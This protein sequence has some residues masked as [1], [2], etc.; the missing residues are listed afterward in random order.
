MKRHA[1]DAWS[2]GF[3]ALFVV[4]A[5]VLTSNR[6]EVLDLSETNVVP[7]VV[8]ALGGAL[9]VGAVAGAR[10]ERR[11]AETEDPE[12]ASE[13]FNEE[14]IEQPA[15]PEA[16]GAQSDAWSIAATP[17]PRRESEPQQGD[18]TTRDD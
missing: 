6:F 15:A 5:A 18:N 4:T 14:V 17:E 11:S 10:S 16:Y 2:L 12:V 7:I 1:F 9:L 13:P 3:G 8:I